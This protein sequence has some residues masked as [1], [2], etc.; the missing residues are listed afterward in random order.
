MLFHPKNGKCNAF[1]NCAFLRASSPLFSFRSFLPIYKFGL[2][3]K[4]KGNQGISFLPKITNQPFLIE[5][6]FLKRTV[7]YLPC[8][9][10]CENFYN[11][12]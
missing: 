10:K 3:R 8:M 4:A 6:F 12:L 5:N 1:C 7:P 9:G 2:R 11:K